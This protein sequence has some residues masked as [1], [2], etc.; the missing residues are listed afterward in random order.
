MKK[1]IIYVCI[2]LL[3]SAGCEKDD[4]FSTAQ[5]LGA[6]MAL[7]PCCGGW[8]IKIDNKTYRFFNLPED[9]NIDLETE[10]FPID[11]SLEWTKDTSGCLG[12][13]ILIFEIIKG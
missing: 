6:D 13:E 3:M 5:I 1:L 9:S 11:V 2:L 7:C 4:D 8:L 12:D 10:I